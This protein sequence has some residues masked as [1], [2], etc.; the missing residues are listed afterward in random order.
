MHVCLFL[1]LS[2]GST[3]PTR[4]FISGYRVAILELKIV[5][6]TLIPS[7]R[8]DPSSETIKWHLGATLAPFVKG[9][10]GKADYGPTMP[11][12]I[13]ELP[14]MSEVRDDGPY[15]F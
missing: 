13:E 12:I 15:P 11:M 7:F 3:V 1:S 6:A 10:D 9:K 8:F 2:C 5:A 4:T 14:K